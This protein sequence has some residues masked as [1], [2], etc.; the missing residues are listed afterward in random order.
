MDFQIRMYSIYIDKNE[1][2]VLGFTQDVS[3]V[4]VIVQ[5]LTN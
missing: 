1:F 3:R 4:R 2:H 5:N